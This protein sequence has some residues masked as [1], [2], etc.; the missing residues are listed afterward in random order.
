MLAVGVHENQDLPLGHPGA[1]LDGG[2]VALLVGVAQAGYT[3]SGADSGNV[4]SGGVIH[5]QDFRIGQDLAQA[6]RAQP[7]LGLRF[8]TAR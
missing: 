5:H 8:G 2:A 7:G 4:V 3:M 6:G 1:G